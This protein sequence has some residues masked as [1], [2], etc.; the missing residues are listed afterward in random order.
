VPR[1]VGSQK[2]RT[3]SESRP[4]HCPSA[5]RVSAVSSGQMPALRHGHL[6]ANQFQFILPLGIGITW[7]SCQRQE[8]ILYRPSLFTA[9]ADARSRSEPHE[10]RSGSLHSAAAKASHDRYG[11]PRPAQKHVPSQDEKG[12]TRYGCRGFCMFAALAVDSGK[13]RHVI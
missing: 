2:H 3:G 12:R 11:L 1:S 5:L 8:R 4:S 6:L 10:Q 9:P 13:L 7:S